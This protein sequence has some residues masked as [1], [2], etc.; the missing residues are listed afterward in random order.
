MPQPARLLSRLAWIF[1]PLR[2]RAMPLCVA[3]CLLLAALVAPVI[4]VLEGGC[5]LTEW[6]HACKGVHYLLAAWHGTKHARHLLT[7]QGGEG[8]AVSCRSAVSTQSKTPSGA[9]LCKHTA[10]SR[11]QVISQP[12]APDVGSTVSA[13]VQAK[14]T[15]RAARPSPAM[16]DYP[17]QPK[18]RAPKG[19]HA[20]AQ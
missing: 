3:L 12:A 13:A 6:A 1:A 14:N 10:P 9:Q 16:R 18:R 4:A 2:S 20:F 19:L 5:A 8:E 7:S 11:P 17:P 15:A